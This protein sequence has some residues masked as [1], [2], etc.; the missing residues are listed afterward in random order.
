MPDDDNATAAAI[1]ELAKQ[2]DHL[3]NA[4]AAAA[5][6]IAKAIATGERP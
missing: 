6:I 5:T 2:V 3:G 4:I 1:R